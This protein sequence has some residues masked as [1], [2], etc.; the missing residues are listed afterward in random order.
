ML[1][2]FV[3]TEAYGTSESRSHNKH[4]RNLIIVN[5][6]L[7][8]NTLIISLTSLVPNCCD[9]P[10]CSPSGRQFVLMPDGTGPIPVPPVAAGQGSQV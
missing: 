1:V 7:R 2:L 5:N 10:C 4:I 3:I 6:Y 8:N 9:F